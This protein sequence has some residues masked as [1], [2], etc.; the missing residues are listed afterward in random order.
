MGWI[1]LLATKF[2]VPEKKCKRVSEIEMMHDDAKIQKKHV[3]HG[4]LLINVQ[5]KV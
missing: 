4:V 3:W 2:L 5:L 1:S